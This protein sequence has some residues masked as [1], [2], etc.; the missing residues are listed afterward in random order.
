MDLVAFLVC[1]LA[2]MC[3]CAGSLMA[4]FS[5]DSEYIRGYMNHY[6]NLTQFTAMTSLP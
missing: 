3:F 5:V 6:A 4:C 1:T 2:T